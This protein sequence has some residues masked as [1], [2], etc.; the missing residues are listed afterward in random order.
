VPNTTEAGTVLYLTP[1]LLSK[2]WILSDMRGIP[3]LGNAAI[4]MPHERICAT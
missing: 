4:D 1:M 2:I 3:D